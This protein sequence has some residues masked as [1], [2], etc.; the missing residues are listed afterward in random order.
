MTTHDR[1]VTEVPAEVPCVLDCVGYKREAPS[2]RY[3]TNLI[4][5]VPPGGRTTA[6][7]LSFCDRSFG[8]NLFCRCSPAKYL[9]GSV[10]I[11]ENTGI[12]DKWI[13]DKNPRMR[14]DFNL[15]KDKTLREIVLAIKERHHH[16]SKTYFTDLIVGAP[17][18]GRTTAGFLSF[19]DRSFGLNLFCRCSPAKY[20]V[21]S[22]SVPL[23]IK[24]KKKFFWPLQPSAQVSQKKP[25]SPQ[26]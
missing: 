6:G 19:C 7:F 17:P 9:V 22:V 20:L 1:G 18:G 4:V 12:R 24:I 8:L 23:G 14:E 11:G 16:G 10:V 13:R 26:P 15:G 21:G 2:W 5:G 25:S 3:F